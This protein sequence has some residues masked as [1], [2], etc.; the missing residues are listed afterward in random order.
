MSKFKNCILINI[1]GC[2]RD[3]LYELIDSGKIPAASL[4]FSH[5]L[6]LDAAETVFPSITLPAQASG[7]TGCPPRMHGITLNLWVER[8]SQIKRVHNYLEKPFEVLSLYGYNIK[9]FIRQSLTRRTGKGSA[10]RHLSPSAR[11]IYEGAKDAG[12]TSLVGFHYFSRGVSTRITPSPLDIGVLLA[13]KYYRRAYY[14]YEKIMI[15]S[16]IS[17][18]YT[19]LTLPTIYSV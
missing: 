10:D 17:V 19:H 11:T 2:R 5:G 15:D 7:I 14:L 9:E 1:D 6:R 13:G 4:I 16:V 12:I 8:F 18:S 3:V